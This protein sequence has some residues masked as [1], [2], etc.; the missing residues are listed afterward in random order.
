MGRCLGASINCSAWATRS[1][2]RSPGPR[3]LWHQADPE[4]KLKPLLAGQATLLPS[5]EGTVRVVWGAAR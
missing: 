5:L 2:V 3:A 4:F 1:V